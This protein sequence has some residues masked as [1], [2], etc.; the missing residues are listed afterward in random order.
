MW[1]RLRN[2]PDPGPVDTAR[3]LP[4]TYAV[5]LI[6]VVMTIVLVIADIVVPV[7]LPL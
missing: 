7:T 1:A 3:M 6:L 2:R 5:M 4:V